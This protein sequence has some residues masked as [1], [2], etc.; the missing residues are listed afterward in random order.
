VNF[1]TPNA[2]PAPAPSQHLQSLEFCSSRRRIFR[3]HESIADFR[4]DLFRGLRGVD[5]NGIRGLLEIRE[6]AGEDLLAGVV[7][8][9]RMQPLAKQ[10][11]GTLQV[12]ELYIGID[13]KQFAVAALERGACQDNVPVLCI[14]LQNSFANGIEPGMRSS[15]LSG[16]PRDIF[17]MLA[18][19][20]KLSP[21]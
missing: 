2:A 7:P 19:E 5:R 21:S 16:M 9:S 10:F 8:F 11:V 12:D 1:G 6:L 18:G 14:P 13:L 4:D 3:Q 20:W 15:S 17:S